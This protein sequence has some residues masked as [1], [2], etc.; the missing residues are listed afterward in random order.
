MITEQVHLS[1][2]EKKKAFCKYFLTLS[3]Y[4]TKQSAS[5][6]TVYKTL[7]QWQDLTKEWDFMQIFNVYQ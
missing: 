2:R 7:K 1:I 6:T 5:K 4:V 3:N